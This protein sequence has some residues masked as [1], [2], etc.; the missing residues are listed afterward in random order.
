MGEKKGGGEF[1]QIKD[2]E[3]RLWRTAADENELQVAK[4]GVG[5]SDANYS[6]T[7]DCGRDPDFV[8]FVVI[9]TQECKVWSPTV[10]SRA[11]E[12]PGCI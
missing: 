11:S 7:A 1:A 8:C 9:P 6:V 12:S 10:Q 3:N 2:T 5:V 4:K